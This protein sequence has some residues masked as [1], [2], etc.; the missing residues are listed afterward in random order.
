MAG[1]QAWVRGAA[2]LCVMTAVADRV[3]WKY[4]S[5]DAYRLFL[6]DA[7]H[8]AQTFVLLA[9]A[10]GLGAFTTAAL[11][12]KRIERALD[13]DGVGEFPVYL[14]GAGT[15]RLGPRTSAAFQFTTTCMG[16]ERPSSSRRLRRKRVPSEETSNRGM[17]L[18]DAA[19]R[20]SKSALGAPT[21]S[22]PMSRVGTA[23]NRL[24]APT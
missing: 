23:I 18:E 6:L 4:A 7:G 2:F 16:G 15:Q 9:T 14:C 20:L 3:F 11:S 13:L 1:G 24:S 10:S 22:P 5:A 21:S 19:R 12:E 8:L 17:S